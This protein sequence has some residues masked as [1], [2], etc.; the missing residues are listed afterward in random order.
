[1]NAPDLHSQSIAARELADAMRE[2]GGY[3]TDDIGL[4][5]ESEC[6]FSEAVSAAVCR[7][8]ELDALADAARALATRYSDRA[9]LMTVRRE[10]LRDVLCAALERSGVPL[11]MRL[12][13]GTVGISRPAPTALVVDE[14][15]IPDAYMRTTVTKKPDMRAITASLRERLAVPGAVLRN[16]QPALLVRVR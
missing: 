5:I 8:A 12:P 6:D 7:L 3:D 2:H 15:A 9:A 16:A 1:M 4:V 13:S 10:K 11:P 14:A